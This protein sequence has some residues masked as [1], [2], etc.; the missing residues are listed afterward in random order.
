MDAPILPIP[1]MT[2]AEL[3]NAIAYTSGRISQVG[4]AT[5]QYWA[6]C[7]HLRELLAIQKQRAAMLTAAER[8]GE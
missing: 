3:A 1:L 5:E 7:N 8:K 6:F 4:T 2:N